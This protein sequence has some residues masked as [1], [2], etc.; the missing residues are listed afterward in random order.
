ME[1]LVIIMCIILVIIIG[2]ILYMRGKRKK[3]TVDLLTMTGKKQVPY[4]PNN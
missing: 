1:F 3:E 4:E 2:I